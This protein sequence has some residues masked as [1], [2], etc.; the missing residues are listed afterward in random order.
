MAA[1][2]VAVKA[3]NSRLREIP[4]QQFF[5]LLR[6]RP[7]KID[8]LA[9][10]RCT[11]FR[12][13]SH[14]SAVVTL[15]PSLLLVMGERDGAIAALQGLAAGSTKHDWR[16]SAPVEQHHSLFFAFQPQLD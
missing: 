3:R 11:V 5:E 7:K 6:A 12:D 16:I 8:V 14:E 4:V 10:A 13:G 9:A 2:G 15:H 1:H